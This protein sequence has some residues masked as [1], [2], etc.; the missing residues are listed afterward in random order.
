VSRI[1]Q[2]VRSQSICLAIVCLVI[3]CA[4]SAFAVPPE[5]TLHV[6]GQITFNAQCCVSLDRTIAATEPEKPVPVVV[7]FEV[8]RIISEGGVHRGFLSGLM[9]NGGPCTFYGPAYV[10]TILETV[11]DN[12]TFQWVVL[13]SDGLRPGTNTFTLCGGGA[14]GSTSLTVAS[15]TMSARLSN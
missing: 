13:P 1:S 7:T 6:S 14:F 8:G 4:A 11:V 2:F 12:R 9:V 15:I 3:G 10:P 5:E